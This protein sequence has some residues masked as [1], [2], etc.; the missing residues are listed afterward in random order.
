M[1]DGIRVQVTSLPE[2]AFAGDFQQ[3]RNQ[4]LDS[5]TAIQS[6]INAGEFETALSAFESQFRPLVYSKFM[7][8]PA[9]GIDAFRESVD[10]FDAIL[11]EILAK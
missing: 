11:S 3:S 10:T 6:K 5:L 4:L 1:L 9:S 7:P 8:E 2:S